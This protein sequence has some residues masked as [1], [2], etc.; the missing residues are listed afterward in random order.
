V[1]SCE[2]VETAVKQIVSEF[3]GRLDIFVANSGI[4]WEDGPILDGP[5]ERADKVLAVNI[6]GTLYCAKAAGA[7][8]RRQQKEGT[9]IDGKPLEGYTYG[10]FIATASMSGSIVNVPQ[11]QAVYNSS[12]AAVIHL[13]KC[14]NTDAVLRAQ[15]IVAISAFHG[16]IP[17]NSR[18]HLTTYVQARVSLLNG[19]VSHV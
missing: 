4:A 8:F 19:L 9:T 1:T 14:A 10:S 11:M 17:P 7:H 15:V 6:N 2:D 5:M 3:N 18:C 12:K 16:P 13:C